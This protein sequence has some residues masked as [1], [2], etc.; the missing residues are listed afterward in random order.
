MEGTHVNDDTMLIGVVA[1]LV[2][3]PYVIAG[4]LLTGSGVIAGVCAAVATLIV[5]HTALQAQ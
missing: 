3:P 5:Y 4:V 1:A 2:M